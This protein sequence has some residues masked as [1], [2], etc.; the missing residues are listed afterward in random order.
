MQ[1]YVIDNKATV[2]ID[3][4]RICIRYG[5]GMTSSVPLEKAEGIAVIGYAQITTQ[6]IAKCLSQGINIRYYSNR[7]GYYGML[8]STSHAN[9]HRLRQQVKLTE[10]HDFTITLAQNI[11]TAKV[12]NQL[13]VLRRYQRR[14]QTK[15]DGIIDTIQVMKEKIQTSN[16]IAEMSGYE[17]NAAR[18]YF[19]GLS[20][21]VTN[22][23]FEFSG[24]TRMPPK[25]KF[26][27][28][29]SL[30][31]TI[32]INELF[33]VI[34]SRGLSPYLAF[35]H[36]DRERHPALASDLIEEWRAV[37]I[38]SLAMALI[39]GNEIDSEHFYSQ[40][41]SPGVYFTRDGLRIYLTKLE[42]KLETSSKY[43][44][45]ISH[46]LTFRRA[47]DSQVI[48]LCKALE[49]GD[50]NLYTPLKIR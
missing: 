12:H 5:D 1:I 42:K 2:G 28:M 19:S 34:E 22:P 3:G 40:E 43:L 49:E 15:L 4:G 39:N 29:I 38:D 9:P 25:D 26:N 14:T 21:L 44:T 23:D 17:G 36:Q 13:T 30:G 18:Q 33:G 27:S 10:D 11:L 41:D 45:H 32:L 7:G 37:I 35:I 48:Q 50:P 31:Y 46:P 8:S 6:C 24:R 20:R 16:N 47:V